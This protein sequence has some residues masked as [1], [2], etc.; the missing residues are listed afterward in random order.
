MTLKVGVK[1]IYYD[2]MYVLGDHLLNRADLIPCRPETE[3]DDG[4]PWRCTLLIRVS[5]FFL[6]HGMPEQG[7]HY[8]SIHTVD[9]CKKTIRFCEKEDTEYDDEVEDRLNKNLGENDDWEITNYGIDPELGGRY[10]VDFNDE[11]GFRD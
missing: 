8:S 5:Q 7:S 1:S 10:C 9:D 3:D 11:V 4:V 2:I 6:L